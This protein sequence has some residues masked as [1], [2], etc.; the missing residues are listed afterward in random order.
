MYL[1][2]FMIRL[3]VKLILI[4]GVRII[5]VPCCEINKIFT[6]QTT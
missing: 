2:A 6:P 5:G 3:R 4:G 1:Y